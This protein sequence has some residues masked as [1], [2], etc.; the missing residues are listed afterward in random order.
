MEAFYARI[1]FF[2]PYDKTQS[3][4]R[5]RKYCASLKATYSENGAVFDAV[6]PKYYLS[7]FSAFQIRL[8]DATSFR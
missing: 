5:L 3:F 1:R 4:F 8:P 2:V 6:I 7:L